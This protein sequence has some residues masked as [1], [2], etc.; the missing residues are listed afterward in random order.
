M[1]RKIVIKTSVRFVV[2]QALLLFATASIIFLMNPIY[3]GNR[4]GVIGQSYNNI[5]HPVK[6]DDDVESFVIK[7]GRARLFFETTAACN[8]TPELF[9]IIP[10]S[11]RVQNEEWYICE[12]QYVNKE[13]KLDVYDYMTRVKWK[14]WEF[15]YPDVD[16]L[17][18]IGEIDP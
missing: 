17:G 15:Q 1:S 2:Y 8:G 9:E 5:F 16:S 14:P 3:W 18:P 7:I 11:E 13:G 4:S 10:G 12:Y 6:Y